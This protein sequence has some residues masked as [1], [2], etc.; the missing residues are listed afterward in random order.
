MDVVRYTE[1]INT[2]PVFNML[3][4]TLSFKHHNNGL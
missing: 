4:S 1:I 3:K 2:N